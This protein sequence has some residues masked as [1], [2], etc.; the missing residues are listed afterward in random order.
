MFTIKG[1][2]V[3]GSLEAALLI[4]AVKTSFHELMDTMHG[5]AIA[6]GNKG[7]ASG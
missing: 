4:H 5:L 2:A 3:L 1:K 6:F 7:G